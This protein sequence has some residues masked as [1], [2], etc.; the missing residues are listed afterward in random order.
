METDYDENISLED[1]IRLFAI[2]RTNMVLLL[3]TDAEL[4]NRQSNRIRTELT[5][6]D[7]FIS[8]ITDYLGPEKKYWIKEA[9]HETLPPYGKADKEK[10]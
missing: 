9:R 5:R 6:I 10:I 2:H 1:C 7:K 4:S 8:D 3:Y